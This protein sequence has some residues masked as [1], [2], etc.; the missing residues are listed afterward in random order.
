MLSVM[1]PTISENRPFVK[2]YS[3]FEANLAHMS[4]SD[5][6]IRLNLIP[7]SAERTFR[8]KC[9]IFMSGMEV[10]YESSC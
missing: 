2:G 8:V 3:E 6:K 5:A 7:Y 4:Y 1:R 10:F 9:A